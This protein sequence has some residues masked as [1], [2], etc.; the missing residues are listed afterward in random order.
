[1]GSS[2]P[3]PQ[4][5]DCHAMGHSWRDDEADRNPK[6]GGWFLKQRCVNGCGTTRQAIID[7]QGN[8]ER[9]HWRYKYLPSYKNIAGWKRSMWRVEYMRKRAKR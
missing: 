9:N 3:G 4:D 8:L 5:I 7:G 6:G 2:K 1:M